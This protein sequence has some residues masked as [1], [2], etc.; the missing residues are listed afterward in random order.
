MSAKIGILSFVNHTH[1]TPAE[2]PQDAVTQ[3]VWPIMG[4][5]WRNL[6]SHTRPSQCEVLCRDEV[7][8]K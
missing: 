2:F 5:D 3:M 1:T 8:Q 7:W 6:R 4:G